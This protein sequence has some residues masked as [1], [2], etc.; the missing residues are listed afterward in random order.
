MG[1]PLTT[2]IIQKRFGKRI[3]QL[4]KE[5]K[6]TQEDLADLIE[7]DRSYMGFVERGERNPTLDKIAK[8]T[9]ALKITLSELFKNV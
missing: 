2:G 8:I 6:L 7:V 4:R 9:K 1:T 3:K 5:R